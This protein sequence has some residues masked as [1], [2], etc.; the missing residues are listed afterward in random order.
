MERLDKLKEFLA[1]NPADNFVRHAMAL[2]YIK[3]NNDEKARE[4]FEE[5]VKRDPGYVGTYYHLGKL[6]ERNADEEQAIRVYEKGI[7]EAKKAGD[8]LSLRELRSVLD[9][10]QN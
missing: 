4:L 9:E 1:E 3:L 6:L 5:I 8:D 7:E 2:E 10:L